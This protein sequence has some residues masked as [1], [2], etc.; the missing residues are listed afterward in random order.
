MGRRPS[1]TSA[2]V[3]VKYGGRDDLDAL[4]ITSTSAFSIQAES[5][6]TELVGP[7]S[8][9]GPS[10]TCSCWSP[11]ERNFAEEAPVEPLRRLRLKCQRVSDE[12]GAVRTL[13]LYAVGLT[14]FIG[15]VVM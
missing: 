10:D 6:T 11:R 3:Y 5:D 12:S 4:L 14:S 1:R 15:S 13:Q 9:L 7:A 8:T 2:R